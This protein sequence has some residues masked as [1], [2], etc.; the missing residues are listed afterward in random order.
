MEIVEPR[1]PPQH[2]GHQRP[3]RNRRIQLRTQLESSSNEL[4]LE[5]SPTSPSPLILEPFEDPS[6]SLNGPGDSVDLEASGASEPYTLT[7]T[8]TKR[9][10][11]PKLTEDQTT[12]YDPSSEA[13]Q[14]WYEDQRLRVLIA[15][16]RLKSKCRRPKRM[17]R[18]KKGKRR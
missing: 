9:A 1:H 17:G 8:Y 3:R 12:T 13:E 4:S 6:L 18:P 16:K 10:P 5:K 2:E 11:R 7:H 15:L 14:K